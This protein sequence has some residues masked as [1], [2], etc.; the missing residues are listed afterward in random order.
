MVEDAKGA[1]S[2][3]V[4]VVTGG[5]RNIGRAVVIA[6]AGE[7]AAVVV[8]AHRAG[9]AAEAVAD[10]VRAGGGRAIAQS[11]D[12]TDEVAVARLPD[13]TEERRVGKGGVSKCIDRWWQYREKKKTSK[14]RKHR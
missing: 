1:L 13:R 3:K 11:A 4:A 5:A 10:E 12:V 7:G 9:A 8:N 2:G 6:L 14:H